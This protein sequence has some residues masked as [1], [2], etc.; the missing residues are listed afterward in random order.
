MKYFTVAWATG[1][2]S[3]EEFEAAVPAYQKHI[4]SLSL[5]ADVRRLVDV[6][7]QDAVVEG[8]EMHGDNFKLSL[9][10]GDLQRGY[11][12]TEITYHGFKFVSGSEHLTS[13][14]DEAVEVVC[15]E[16]DR[17]EDCYIHRI[18]LSTYAHAEITFLSALVSTSPRETR[19]RARRDLTP[20]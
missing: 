12:S 8:I 2:L 7:I 9:I 16:I 6:D 20:N 14:F 13:A 17:Y 19:E 1:E 11:C 18:L 10:A 5:P 3:D 15:D 4:L